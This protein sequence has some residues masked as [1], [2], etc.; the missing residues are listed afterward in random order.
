MSHTYFFDRLRR[1]ANQSL[2]S[3]VDLDRRKF[4]KNASVVT[5]GL[6]ATPILGCSASKLF[7]QDSNYKIAI[8]GA[9]LSG[10]SC[11]YQLSKI[12][13]PVD[14]FEASNRIGGRTYSLRNHFADGQTAE[15]GGELIDSNHLSVFRIAK[16]LG[17]KIDDCRQ[18]AKD[19]DHFIINGKIIKD[20][21][22]LEKFKPL[23]KIILETRIKADS[24]SDYFNTIDQQSITD[25]LNKQND[26]AAELKQLIK[27]AYTG[28][29]GLEA[30]KQSAISLLYFIDPESSDEFKIFGDSDERYHIKNGN[31]QMAIGMASHLI[32]K[33][34][35]E[36]R[37]K[38]IQ[39]LDNKYQLSF[40]N[41]SNFD[42]TRYDLVVIALPFTTL[43]LID[44][45]E[46]GFAAD[47]VKLINELGYGTNAKIMAGFKSR[48]W[49]KYTDNFALI[50][51]EPIQTV[52]ETSRAQ[53]G[54][55]GILTNFLGGERGLS[56]NEGTADQQFNKSLSKLEITYPGLASEYLPDKTVRMHWPTH[57]HTLGSYACYLPGQAATA[58]LEGRRENN[59]FFCGEHCS[60]NF[61]G[62]MEGA[63]ETGENVAIQIGKEIQALRV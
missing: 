10:T 44:I 52:W 51:D 16:E 2:S 4:I 19:S 62:F 63:I 33:P 1:L 26:I 53:T 56:S 25:W 18:G 5:A 23:A 43:R 37:L 48:P 46:A 42:Q 3:E 54:K 17:L 15:L 39:K 45:T 58:G 8:I 55:S 50:A 38:K 31:D 7:N 9:G 49:Q 47:K 59:V 20:Q 22:I 60:E 27:I 34:F 36:H 57:P 41:Q 30:E 24:D 61:Q 21:W 35:L 6:L 29:F 11:A 28:E 32:R 14:L 40:V 13:I 12:G